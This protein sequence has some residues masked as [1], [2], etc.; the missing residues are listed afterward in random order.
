MDMPTP[1]TLALLTTL[2]LA[3]AADP[4]AE[5]EESD[6]RCA[7]CVWGPPLLNSHGVNGV[8]VAAM[9]TTG[10]FHDGWRLSEVVAAGDLGVI[11]RKLHDVHAEDGV[12]YGLDDWGTVVSGQEFIGSLW[13]IEL[14]ATGVKEFMEIH[15]YHPDPDAARYTF[16]ASASSQGVDAPKFYTCPKDEDTGDYSAVLFT[17]LDVD[18]DTGKHLSRPDTIY[19]ACAAAAVG[20]AAVWGYSPWSTSAGTHQIASRAVRADYC[21]NGQSYT[22]SGTP[23]QLSDVF[24]INVF[25]DPSQDTEALWGKKGAICL[26]TPRR[27]QADEVVCDGDKLPACTDMDFKNTPAAELSSKVWF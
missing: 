22:E 10:A 3:C 21:G 19:F 14:E 7:H 12:L 13:T 16:I 8:P 4:A 20:K 27:V 23:L 2:L 24:G 6:F 25:S 5:P 26:T 1:R 15:A 9:D 18:L 17:D 11:N